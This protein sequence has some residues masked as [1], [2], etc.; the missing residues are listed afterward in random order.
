MVKQ[1]RCISYTMQ[2]CGHQYV[3]QTQ[4][5]LKIRFAKHLQAIRDRHRLGVF[6]EHFCSREC[7]G[8]ENILIQ[9]LYNIPNIEE[10][11]KQLETLWIDTWP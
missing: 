3:G 11:I 7:Q 5:S 6:Q 9:L 2:K 10:S 1:E 4:Q 8:V